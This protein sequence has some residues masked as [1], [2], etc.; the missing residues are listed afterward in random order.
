M[1]RFYCF[2]LNYL[3]LSTK[4][5]K[6]QQIYRRVTEIYLM[7]SLMMLFFNT[8]IIGKGNHKW[9]GS[10]RKLASHRRH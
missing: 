8:M 3:M 7:D 9:G 10:E 2:G 4:K 6:F 5:R 1:Q